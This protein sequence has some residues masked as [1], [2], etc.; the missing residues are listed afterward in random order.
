[1]KR[2]LLS[3]SLGLLV[4]TSALAQE[5]MTPEKLWQVKPCQSVGVEQRQYPSH[6]SSNHAQV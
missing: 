1:M 3:V 2:I 4:N 6:L 5:V